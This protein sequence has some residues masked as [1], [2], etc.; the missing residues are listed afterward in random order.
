MRNIFQVI[1]YLLMMQGVFA[2]QNDFF[3][4]AKTKYDVRELEMKTEYQKWYPTLTGE[5]KQQLIKD[6]D[7]VMTK[8]D[9][10]RNVEYLNALIKTKVALDLG[11]PTNEEPR[12]LPAK[13]SKYNAE[14]EYLTGEEGLRKELIENFYAN[15]LN[16]KGVLSATLK[17][18]VGE[19]GRIDVVKVLNGAN[20]EFNKQAEIALYLMS[21]YFTPAYRKGKPVRSFYSIPIKINL[22]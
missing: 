16:G 17:F 19:D 6:Y 2:Q 4:E 5:Q 1:V 14:A 3:R 11:L 21:F 20:R 22:N 10:M 7:M 9:S 8:L 18:E 13:S 15:N 12:V